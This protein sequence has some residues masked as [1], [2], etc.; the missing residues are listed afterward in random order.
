MGRKTGFLSKTRI[1]NIITVLKTV[2]SGNCVVFEKQMALEK[3]LTPV[4]VEAVTCA[5][6]PLCILAGAGTG[7]T[8]VITHRMAWLIREQ[9]V[10]PEQIL[11]VT[12]TNK[13]AREMAKRVED[14]VPGTGRRVQL[15]TFHGM[16]ARFLR[17]YGYFIDVASDFVIYDE[18]DALR[19]LKELWEQDPGTRVNADH[20]AAWH[21][22]ENWR[23]QG[24]GPPPHLLKSDDPFIAKCVRVFDAYETA[25]KR[26]NALDF[27]GLLIGWLRL[28]KSPG[29]AARFGAQ[30]QHLLVDEYQDTNPVQAQIVY[31]LAA[32]AK[33]VAVVGDDDQSIYSWRGA[34]ADNMKHFLQKCD[35]AKLIKLEENHRSTSHIL[36]GANTVIANN[37]QRLGKNL[38]AMGEDG[39]PVL[40]LRCRDDRSEA[41][42][43]VHL[44]EEQLMRG[45][46][47][48]E[49]AILV[50]THA[51]SRVFEERLLKAGIPYQLV[52]GTRFY[53][54]REVKDVL[55][56]LRAAVNPASN[57]DLLRALTAIPRGV[58]PASVQKM[59]DEAHRRSVPVYDVMSNE[60]HLKS[61]S[62]SP[63]IRKKIARFMDTLSSLS[64]QVLGVGD[65][66]MPLLSQGSGQAISAKDA[67]ALAIDLSGLSDHFESQQNEEAADR[68]ENLQELVSAAAAFVEEAKADDEDITIKGF[69]SQAVLAT[70]QGN[71]K[72]T[73]QGP[74][75]HL[76]TLHAAKGL[77]FESV[78]LC[79]L[80]EY[81]FPHARALADDA[82]PGNLEEERRLAYVG[83]TRA[84]R[85]L[86]LTWAARRMVRGE[87]KRR[88]SSRF[89]AELDPVNCRGDFHLLNRARRTPRWEQEHSFDPYPEAN[90][91]I[92]MPTRRQQAIQN[93]LARRKQL[94]EESQEMRVELE[95]GFGAVADEQL[96]SGDRVRH[97]VFG[98]GEVVR[99]SG[100]GKLG[101]ATVLFDHELDSRTIILKHLEVIATVKNV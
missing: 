82:D 101:R 100:S 32:T 21:F 73:F 87:V 58:G 95:P 75:I 28:L 96:H 60:A 27:S 59:V 72:N 9:R 25:L 43:V 44:I 66:S 80:E 11:G 45:I 33:S 56:M 12:F 41:Q 24:E 48:H 3:M 42:K 98:T 6:G 29:G 57:V 83:M 46:P 38:K 54:R 81:G 10:A 99:V 67:V 19:M 78:F 79:A 55:A 47:P 93:V 53:A 31:A 84:K 97:Q 30:V 35:G 70:D 40:L 63:A 86:T 90:S 91:P 76:M 23:H 2:S 34:V 4:Q 77:E 15:G 1:L 64:Q 22:F 17:R 89:L 39:L 88:N 18:D 85:E 13:A 20:K 69:L 14:L 52:G 5:Q 8:R 49:I 7:K 26:M 62:I 50:R 36:H 51:D 65:P 71:N 37:T 16:A 74:P 68:L 94:R 61:A 92:A